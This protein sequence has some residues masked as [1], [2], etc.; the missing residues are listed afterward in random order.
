[1]YVRGSW[2]S[3]GIAVVIILAFYVSVC[4]RESAVLA[5]STSSYVAGVGVF[6]AVA[7]G[8]S[9]AGTLLAEPEPFFGS[10][11]WNSILNFVA[12]FLASVAVGL[13]I[14][15]LGFWAPLKNLL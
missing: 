4:I 8:L 11:R 9:I 15:G 14:E 5:S 6:S 13:G 7:W 10:A 12:A 1:M 3:I 2:I